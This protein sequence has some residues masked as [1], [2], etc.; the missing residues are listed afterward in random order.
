MATKA[1]VS[2]LLKPIGEVQTQA[3]FG[4]HIHTLG[5]IKWI[6]SQTGSAEVWVSSYSTSEEFLRGFRLMRQSD[7]IR[8]AKML[9]DVKA[10]KKT[11]QLWRMMQAC[12]DEVY[13]G[14]NHSKVILF[15]A[16]DCVVSVV[17]SQN[18]TYGSRDEST[19]VTTEP[20]VFYDLL[21]GY[22]EHCTNKSLKINGNYTGIDEK[23][24]RLG[25]DFDSDI[26]MSV[27]L[28]INEDEL[29][30]EILKPSS[31]LHRAYYL[32]MATV[33][34]QLRKNELDLA[35]AGS[36]QA[37]QRTHEYLNQML[38]EIRV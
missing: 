25:R 27:L 8:S 17:T 24:A 38:E 35:A 14:E 1:K 11:V 7:S 12:F 9:L 33:K 26:E 34:Q 29:R 18:Q 16:A 28:D 2:D 4:R 6:L 5:L 10:S 15:R 32:G 22:L 31:K 23:R 13:L 19:I 21:H 3:Y 36:P 30:E 20:Q 37:V